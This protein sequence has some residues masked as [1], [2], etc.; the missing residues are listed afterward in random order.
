MRESAQTALSFA[1]AF[2]TRSG[3][4]DPLSKSPEIHVHVPAG[5]IP[6]DGPSAGATIACA[7]VSLLLLRP[8]R[9]GVAMTGEVTLRGRILA[10]GGLK[11]KLLAAHRARIH[12]VII[13]RENQPDLA[14]LPKSLTRALQVILVSDMEELLREALV[15]GSRPQHTRT[16]SP[17]RSAGRSEQSSHGAGRKR[18]A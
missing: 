16:H 5:A 9:P 4:A 3:A 18:T 7:L 8:V 17:D 1:R 12:T 2:A 10:V 14:T 6:K 13:P 11:E 15:S